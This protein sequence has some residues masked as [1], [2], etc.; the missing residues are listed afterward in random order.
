MISFVLPIVYFETLREKA[1]PQSDRWCALHEAGRKTIER[2]PCCSF[3]ITCNVD[4]IRDLKAL[5]EKYCPRALPV[6]ESAL[7]ARAS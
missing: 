7:L 6:L 4:T 5:A 1:R 3:T 2:Q